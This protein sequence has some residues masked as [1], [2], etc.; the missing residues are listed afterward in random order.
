MELLNSVILNWIHSS[1]NRAPCVWYTQQ[2]VLRPSLG[3]SSSLLAL[4]CSYWNIFSLLS[5]NSYRNEYGTLRI[6]R[7][8][9][10]DQRNHFVRSMEDRSNRQ[11][12]NRSTYR[13]ILKNKIQKKIRGEANRSIHV[14]VRPS[15]LLLLTPVRLATTMRIRERELGTNNFIELMPAIMM[16]V[17]IHNRM[18]AYV[19]MDKR[20]DMRTHRRWWWWWCVEDVNMTLAEGESYGRGTKLRCLSVRSSVCPEYSVILAL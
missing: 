13:E 20:T 2:H 10:R 6:C 16:R 15:V 3:S 17:R 1:Q 11:T 12:Q 5:A 7:L 4:F 14:F 8:R 9:R 19:S 18:A